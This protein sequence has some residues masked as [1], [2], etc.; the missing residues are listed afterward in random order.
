MGNIKLAEMPVFGN[1]VCWWDSANYRDVYVLIMLDF[2][3]LF[4]LHVSP[5]D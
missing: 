2:R 4:F 1:I 3:F 5:M